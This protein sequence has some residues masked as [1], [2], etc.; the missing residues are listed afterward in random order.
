MSREYGD[1]WAPPWRAT[2]LKAIVQESLEHL[3]HR[4]DTKALRM[5]RAIH[6]ALLGPTKFEL[7]HGPGETTSRE[8]KQ[9]DDAIMRWLWN[10]RDWASITGAAKALKA[11]AGVGGLVATGEPEQEFRWVDQ[12]TGEE[13]RARVDLWD[14]ASGTLL[15]I[16]H[17]GCKLTQA[18]AEREFA[19]W[20]THLQLAH[21]QSGIEACGGTVRRVLAAY[22]EAS[23][24]HACILFEPDPEAMEVGLMLRDGALRAA[25]AIRLGKREAG[26][27]QDPG[28]VHRLS[29]P[30]WATTPNL[31]PTDD[32]Q[33]VYA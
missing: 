17:V 11:N 15:E 29:L 23:A 20:L 33:E 12:A 30:A 6:L 32:D 5:G 9:C 4:R 2:A 3:R 24:P 8:Q 22:V 28:G 7:C 10:P 27:F 16:K 25:K 14:E 19:K 26:A 1:P 21:Y 31:P 18:S 13:C